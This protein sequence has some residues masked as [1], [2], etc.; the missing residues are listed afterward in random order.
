MDVSA[1][2]GPAVG[3]DGPVMVSRPVQKSCSCMCGV[4]EHF[5]NE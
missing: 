2:S 1:V 5:N 3:A 4:K